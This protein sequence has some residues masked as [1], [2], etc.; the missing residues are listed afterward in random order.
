MATNASLGPDAQPTK[1]DRPTRG[2]DA[3]KSAHNDGSTD[4]QS[5]PP[6]HGL[7]THS[8]ARFLWECP[9]DTPIEELGEKYDAWKRRQ[10]SEQ[11]DLGR[12]NDE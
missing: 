4:E 5:N 7:P 8:T 9:K 1:D 3:R 6:N 10:N 11:S 2:R 12:W